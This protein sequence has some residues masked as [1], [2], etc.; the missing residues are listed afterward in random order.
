MD[1][2]THI[3]KALGLEEGQ[4]LAVDSKNG[5]YC[6]GEIAERLEAF[7][8]KAEETALTAD[9]N[10]SA[11]AKANETIASLN[12]KLAERANEEIDYKNQLAE[13][14]KALTEAQQQIADLNSKV[15]ERDTEIESLKADAQKAEETASTASEEHTKALADKDAEIEELKKQIAGKDAEIEELSKNAPKTPVPSPANT[16]EKDM[17]ADAPHH[18][19]K[20]GMSAEESRKALQERKAELRKHF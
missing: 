15:A 10:I 12:G 18:F 14:D 7:L 5:F 6:N 1:K 16:E 8:G 19:Y 3:E 9:A 17:N 2:Y 11:L 13:K 4:E 20:P